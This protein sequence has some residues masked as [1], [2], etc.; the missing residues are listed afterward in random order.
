MENDTLGNSQIL[1]FS[2]LQYHLPTAYDQSTI[3]F[4]TEI[5]GT[6]GRVPEI[7]TTTY[8]LYIYIYELPIGHLGHLH[9]FFHHQLLAGTSCEL[10][11]SEPACV[12][13]DVGGTGVMDDGEPA[14][15][16]IKVWCCKVGPKKT[17]LTTGMRQLPT[18]EGEI[19]TGKPIDFRPCIGI[20]TPVITIGLGPTLC[21]KSWLKVLKPTIVPF[22]NFIV[23]YTLFRTRHTWKNPQNLTITW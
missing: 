16:H 10:P 23:Y 6:L 17:I 2:L 19:T 13:G 3:F 20:I 14:K 22:Q 7:C 5:L 4:Q 21:P 11:L 8:L 12:N 18:K 15:L 9:D 1:D